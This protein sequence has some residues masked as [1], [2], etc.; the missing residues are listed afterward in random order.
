MTATA[1][2][3]RL[4]MSADDMRRALVRIAHEI[5]ERN[6][7]AETLVLVGVP[8]PGPLL[9]QRIAAHIE[10]F[11]SVRVPTGSLDIAMH[12]DDLDRRPHAPDVH[13]SSIPVNVTDRDVVLVDDVLYT[14]RSVRAA[15]D[16]LN[17]FGRPRTIQ[18][19]VM[20]DRGHRELPIRADYVGKNLPTSDVDVVAVH[21]DEL[22]GED[23][24]RIEPR[25]R[26]ETGGAPAS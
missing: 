17:D 15:M 10:A 16:A 23:A 11:E 26:E 1:G 3:G 13:P 8:R 5:V 21:L 9:A 24:V 2:S 19:A 20:V 14:G 12:R 25:P 7:G 6:R 4:V 22:E 18:L